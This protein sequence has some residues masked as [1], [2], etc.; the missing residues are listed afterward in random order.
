MRVYEVAL[1][2]M[3]DEV[4]VR[5]AEECLARCT[6]W[7]TVAEVRRA[8]SQYCSGVAA[9][10]HAGAL[11]QIEREGRAMDEELARWEAEHGKWL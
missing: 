8:A 7:P 11:S 10:A 3:P 9:Q 2:D 4:L 5:A 1:A 6:F